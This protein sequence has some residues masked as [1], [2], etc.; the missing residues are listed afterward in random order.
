MEHG[1]RDSHR[2][3]SLVAI[4]AVWL[5]EISRNVSIMNCIFANGEDITCLIR[6]DLYYS[7]VPS[8]NLVNYG[9]IFNV[10]FGIFFDI[11]DHQL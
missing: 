6:A 5:Y 4:P 1:N 9:E 2:E 8:K 11:V 7:N 3:I 10:M